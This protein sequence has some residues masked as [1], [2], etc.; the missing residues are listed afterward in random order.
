MSDSISE[1]GAIYTPKDFANLLASWAIRE[2][3]HRVIDTGIGE[4][5]LTFAAYERL[6]ELGAPPSSARLQIY[7]SEIRPATYE[8]FKSL[9]A[10]QAIEFPNIKCGDFFSYELPEVET[11]IGNPPYVRC[12][13]IQDVDSIREKVF[14]K[15]RELSE[16]DIS[17]L[18]D[19]YIYF[20]IYAASHLRPGG[21]IAVITADSWL[22]VR[23]GIAFKRYL[24]SNFKIEALVNLDR[25]VFSAEVRPVLV[26]AVKKD[27]PKIHAS[28]TLQFIRVKNGLPA[29][30]LLSLIKKPKATNPDVLITPIETRTL[31][32]GSPWGIHFKASDLVK[33]I[34]ATTKTTTL[35]T[36]GRTRIGIQ[37][38]AKEFF[39]LTPEKAK[40]AKIEKRFLRPFIYSSRYWD[41]PT[42]DDGAT[43]N[44]YLFCCS[45]DKKDIKGTNALRYIRQGERKVV[46]V[47]GKNETVI[48]YHNKER[49][50]EDYRRNWYD[51]KTLIMRRGRAEI[52]IPRLIAKKFQVVWNKAGFESGELYIEFFPNEPL[53]VEIST[54]L[55]ILNSTLFET[56]LRI[57]AQLYGGGSYNISPGRIGNTLVP[58]VKQLTQEDKSRLNEAYTRLLVDPVQGRQE[59]DQALS[60]FLGF[61]AAKHQLVIEIL[62]DLIRLGEMK[63][64]MGPQTVD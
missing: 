25:L 36:L 32:A 62:N 50:K 45:K 41:K 38:L 54:Y 23:Y 17:R 57:D 52:L 33:E 15:N 20:L 60:L 53:P 39:V 31:D 42:I 59:I 27:A 21:R 64:P 35:S 63:P 55:A 19:L 24:K 14:G 46:K 40:V 56:L 22:N 1:V 11:V 9:A 2:K 26:F 58:D 48:G 29:G 8:V 5:A 16:K 61:D 7:G 4:G 37:T 34:A 18:S 30:K 6:I 51:L 28:E 12:S 43:P 3:H 49:I 47:R 44:A 10:E 13:A